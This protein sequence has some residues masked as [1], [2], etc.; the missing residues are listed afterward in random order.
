MFRISD[1][2]LA[3]CVVIVATL[4]YQH[5]DPVDL[6]LVGIGCMEKVR[7]SCRFRSSSYIGCRVFARMT[8]GHSL[9]LTLQVTGPSYGSTPAGYLPLRTYQDSINGCI[10]LGQ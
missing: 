3:H 9:N 2:S 1:P 4:F 8:N 5:P 7:R 6:Q 10:R